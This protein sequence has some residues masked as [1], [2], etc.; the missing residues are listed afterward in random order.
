MMGFTVQSQGFLM[1]NHR[2]TLASHASHPPHPL[3]ELAA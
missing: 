1:G 3:P 2:S